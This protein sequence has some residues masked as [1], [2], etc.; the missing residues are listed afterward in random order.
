MQLKRE[1]FSLQSSL[2]LPTQKIHYFHIFNS[3]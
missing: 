2:Q 1:Q 3:W